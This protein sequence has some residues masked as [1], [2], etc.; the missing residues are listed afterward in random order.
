MAER[1]KRKQA[2]KE[3]NDLQRE[4][5]RKEQRLRQ[6]DRER[7]KKLYTFVGVALGAALLFILIGVIY[8]FLVLPRQQVARVGDVSI[9]AEQFWKRVKYEQSQLQNQLIRY[10]QL[11]Q[12]FG[13][14]GFFAGQISQLQGTLGSPFALGQQ[15]LNAMLEDA[16]ILQEAAKR[17]LV[18][19]D[20]EVEAAL[21]EEIA[22]SLGLV[23]EPQATATAQAQ[24]DATATAAAWTP[25]PTATVDASNPVTATAT[26]IPTPPIP[27][28]PAILTD[29]LYAETLDAF[30]KSLQQVAG[31]TLD[32]Y[33]Q[34]IR[35]RLLREKLQEVIADERVAT[36]EEAVHARHILLRIR[37][38]APTPTP[39]PEGVTPTP[40]PEGM[41]TPT[42]T[43]EPRNEEQTLAL[44]N[45]L[46]QRLLNGE[47]FAT[48]AAEYS[49]DPG[50]A[51]Q[52]GDLG[53]FGRGR[54]VSPF[55]EA[56]FSL[57]VG[58]ISEP[59]KT[60]FGY[61]IIQVLERD[62]AHPKDENQL[63]QERIQAFQTWLNEQLA[64]EDI[65]RPANLVSLLPA[66]L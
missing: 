26:P 18:V 34:L 55:E 10:Q 16:I 5:T 60:D 48:L 20:E 12:Q 31:F 1:N 61:H 27:P 43:P 44:A 21:R 53:W 62:S 33:K 56:A 64:R 30:Q 29:T 24:I 15:A 65:Q 47:D 32:E 50:S 11:E 35:A 59:V 58:E 45:E 49:D 52:G 3:S 39:L 63:A 42:P 41:P 46:R 4:L 57:P 28:T 7:H 36:T 17:G 8:Q 25:T 37:E 23:T 51:A 13:N 19:T 40:T 6:R 22:N 2:A 9:T 66:G 14:Q 38:P 54:M